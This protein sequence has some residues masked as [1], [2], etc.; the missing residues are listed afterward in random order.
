MTTSR[1]AR[2]ADSTMISALGSAPRCRTARPYGRLSRSGGGH[3]PVHL[4]GGQAHATL[5]GGSIRSVVANGRPRPSPSVCPGV[6]D[7]V[8]VGSLVLPQFGNGCESG[9]GRP[10]RPALGAGSGAVVGGDAGVQ[11]G[12]RGAGPTCS[13]TNRASSRPRSGGDV[14]AAQRWN[15][16][17]VQPENFPPAAGPGRPALPPIRTAR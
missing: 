2:L 13:C 4:G 3:E 6:G 7:D 8:A 1:A 10:C 12:C 11:R 14:G 15:Q 5:G 16:D 17:R 9:L